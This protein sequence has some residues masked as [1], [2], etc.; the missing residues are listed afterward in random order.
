MLTGVRGFFP[1]EV[2]TDPHS[3][4]GVGV[5]VEMGVGGPASTDVDLLWEGPESLGGA[6]RGCRTRLPASY[7][8]TNVQRNPPNNADFC[9]TVNS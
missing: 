7:D 2:A 4:V 5:G 3:G 6:G 9:L 8:P 1:S